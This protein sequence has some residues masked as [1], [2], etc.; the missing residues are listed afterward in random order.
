MSTQN[1]AVTQAAPIGLL[2][3]R[4]LRRLGGPGA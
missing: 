4:I 1:P 2:D 3:A